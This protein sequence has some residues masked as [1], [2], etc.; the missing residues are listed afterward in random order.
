[1]NPEKAEEDQRKIDQIVRE[2]LMLKGVKA[3]TPDDEIFLQPQQ[4]I[5]DQIKSKKKDTNKADT[6]E[7]SEI[8]NGTGP[9][10]KGETD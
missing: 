3:Y 1:M 7:Q 4:E 2:Q 6:G 8:S 9:K 5:T 10:S